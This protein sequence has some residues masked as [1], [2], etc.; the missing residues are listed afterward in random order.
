MLSV[1]VE[2]GWVHEFSPQRSV[3]AAFV[4]APTVPFRVLGVS[5]SRD[6]A[7]IGLDS[8]LSLTRNVALLGSFTGR[9]SGAETAVG[10]FEGLQVTW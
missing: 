4:A 3:N 9:L 2:L 8:K 7:Q 5:A 10:G 6:S 1:L